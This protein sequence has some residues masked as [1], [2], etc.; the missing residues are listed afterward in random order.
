MFGG[1]AGITSKGRGKWINESSAAA[2]LQAD[3]GARPMR[4]PPPPPPPRIMDNLPPSRA[5]RPNWPWRCA[6]LMPTQHL[7]NAPTGGGVEGREKGAEESTCPEC[8]TVPGMLKES[9][10]PRFPSRERGSFSWERARKRFW[11]LF[12]RGRRTD[13]SP[14]AFPIPHH[15][16]SWKGE[17]RC[18]PGKGPPTF[19]VVECQSPVGTHPLITLRLT[20]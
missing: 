1:S 6:Q 12:S 14:R 16:Q 20:W 9:L 2:A 8:I 5:P 7:T 19:W 11:A 17:R 18:A 15:P 4:T 10:E 3:C 13:A